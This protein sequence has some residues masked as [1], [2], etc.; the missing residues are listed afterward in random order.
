MLKLFECTF[1]VQDDGGHRY[2]FFK[3]TY[4]ENLEKAEKYFNDYASDFLGSQG[5][6]DQGDWWFDGGTRALRV[7]DIAEIELVDWMEK[8]TARALIGEHAFCMICR[9]RIGCDKQYEDC[10][11]NDANM[12]RVT[13][14]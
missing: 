2:D 1:R 10:Q 3:T 7:T 8:H 11:F 6:L 4:A 9:H 12:E 5:E 13:S 14:G